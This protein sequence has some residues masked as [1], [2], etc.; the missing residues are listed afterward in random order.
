MHHLCRPIKRTLGLQISISPCQRRRR[1][2]QCLALRQPLQQRSTRCRC[3]LHAARCVH[4]MLAAHTI[5]MCQP[6]GFGQDSKHTCMAL[7]SLTIMHAWFPC[8][9]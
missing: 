7:A 1:Q 8:G 6:H 4:S 5:G 2:R 3:G 9:L